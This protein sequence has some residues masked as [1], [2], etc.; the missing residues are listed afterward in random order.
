MSKRLRTNL[1]KYG[2]FAIVVIGFA[3]FYCNFHDFSQ[4]KLVDRYRVL[5]D[6]FLVPGMLSVFVGILLWISN[7][8]FFYGLSYCLDV[9]RKALIPGGRRKREKYYDYVMRKKE[10]KITGYGFLFISGGVSIAISLVFLMLYYQL[11]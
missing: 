8:G 3:V 9:A 1:L 10:K 2:I 7:D 4:L 6:A 5:C 11:H